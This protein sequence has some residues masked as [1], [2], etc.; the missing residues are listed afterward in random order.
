MHMEPTTTIDQSG[1]RILH[2]CAINVLL[3]IVVSFVGIEDL[4]VT[5]MLSTLPTSLHYHCILITTACRGVH[6]TS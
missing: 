2:S 6:V 5:T 3:T 4:A 1:S